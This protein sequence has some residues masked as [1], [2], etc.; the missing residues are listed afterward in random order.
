MKD[1]T[2]GILNELYG[3]CLTEK[4]RDMKRSYYDYDL[5]LAEIAGQYGI[6]RQAAHDAIRKGEK[7]L[8]ECE[9]KMGFMAKLAG[10]RRGLERLTEALKGGD[11]EGAESIAADILAGI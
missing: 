9:E 11:A 6:S 3:G 4:Q 7:A 1:L 10:I 2:V 8:Y 5:S